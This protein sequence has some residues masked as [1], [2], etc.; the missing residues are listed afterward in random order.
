M[1]RFVCDQPHPRVVADLA[2]LYTEVS[3]LADY[4]QHKAIE[5]ISRILFE[6]LQEVINVD[7][8]A[9][10][11]G[12]SQHVG[13]EACLDHC[14]TWLERLPSQNKRMKAWL[15]EFMLHHPFEATTNPRF[16]PMVFQVCESLDDW[17]KFQQQM[18]RTLSLMWTCKFSCE[19]GSS[20]LTLEDGTLM[21][22]V[23]HEPCPACMVQAHTAMRDLSLQ[24]CSLYAHMS[25][26]STESSD[27]EE[28]DDASHEP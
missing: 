9:G 3:I 1:G 24:K 25:D 16:Q 12:E 26:G 8:N 21:D 4:L 10:S 14:E 2:R 27:S 13:L 23:F 22:G 6:S 19:T 5:T 7:S 18:T 11:L 20:S 28:S 17:V 15:Y